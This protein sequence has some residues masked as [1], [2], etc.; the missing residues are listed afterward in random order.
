VGF[1]TPLYELADYLKWTT[2]GKIQLPDFQRG[3]KWE[4]ERIRQLLVTILRGHPL[5][6]VMLLKTG[7]NQVRFKPKPIEG[8][9]PPAD[10]VPEQLLLDGQQRLTSLTQALTGDG[11]V[12][13]MD[14]RGKLLTRRYYVD[15]ALALE[16]ED[17]ID[18]AVIS[19]P[20]D[21]VVRTNFGKDIVLD[22]SSPEKER[23]NGYFP[24]RLLFAG[25]DTMTWVLA[26]D[27]KT[28]VSQFYAHVVQPATTYNI[29]AIELD[30]ST[31]KAAV[32]TV[33]EK[34]NTGGLPLNAFELLTATFAGDKDYFDANG[35]DFRLNDD[36]KETE[37][38]F[39]A[40]PVLTG[41][42]NTDFLQAVTLLA[43]RKRNRADTSS[44]P[45]AISA[46]R[47][48]VLK[49]ALTDYLDWVGPLREA[50]IWAADFLADRHIFGARVPPGSRSAA[51]GRRLR[52]LLHHSTRIPVPAR[53]RRHGQARSP[54]TSTAARPRR[55][56]LSSRSPRSRKPSTRRTE[57]QR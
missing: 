55:T 46:K 18:E 2:S 26:F 40:Y 57:G 51:T 34:V 49:L 37:A 6:V 22:L 50:F 35:T 4:D 13:T 8:A 48:D 47:E 39:T 33:F 3:Y 15:M 32:A 19:V 23:A 27:D 42:E 45:S 17:R 7:N 1:Q 54:V 38:K 28:Q 29:P 14:S 9:N 53:R 12:A 30:N 20:G 44:R 16:G 52:R 56:P 5:G 11:V 25:A 10:A 24:L 43:T 21:G 31:S 36:W 41:L